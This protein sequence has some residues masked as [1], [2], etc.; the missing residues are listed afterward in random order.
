MLTP[1]L[2]EIRLPVAGVNIVD[3]NLMRPFLCLTRM[4]SFTYSIDFSSSRMKFNI[5]EAELYYNYF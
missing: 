4:P 1:W 2:I 5:V 3:K